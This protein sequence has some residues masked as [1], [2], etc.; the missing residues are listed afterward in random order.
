MS[1]NNRYVTGY[2]LLILTVLMSSCDQQL[3]STDELLGADT[4]FRN[5]KIYTVDRNRT[6]AEALAIKDG[7]ITYVGSD[8]D[9]LTLIGSNTDVIDLGARMVLPG[10]QDVHI[11]P[12]WGGVEASACDLNGLPGVTEYRS[13]ISEYAAANPNVEWIL[14]GGWSMPVFGPGG[15]P[16]RSIIDELVP[17]R[18]VFLTSADGHSG[19]A[20]SRA[21]EIAGITSNTPDPI[22]GRIDRDPKT[23]EPIGSLQEGATTLVTD[24]I[25]PTTLAVRKAG[26]HYAMNMLNGYGITSI[27]A[28]MVTSDELEAYQSIE[29]QGELNL[30]VV[31][32]LW[33]EREKGLEQIEYLETL[34]TQ[35]KSDLIRPTTVKIMQ[36]GVMENY[37][38][39]LLEPYFVPSNT[40]GIPMVEP[41][42]L[43]SA[44][45]ALDASGFQ[46]HFHAIGDAAIRQALNAVEESI[47]ENGQLGHRHHISHLQ[48]INPEDIERFAE[49]SVVANFQPLWAY[50]D[51]YITDLTA[52]FLGDKRM[53]W[54]YPIR[55]IQKSGG[56][57][58]FGSD[59]SVSTAN[60]FHQMETAITRMSAIE[61]TEAEPLVIEE[62]IDRETAIEAFTINAAYVNRSEH[63]TGSIEVGKYADLI[64]L[65]QNLFEVNELDI[66]ETKVMLTLFEGRVVH[67]NISEF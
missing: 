20:N 42:L 45:T 28:A 43:K 61:E 30:R 19:W 7:R 11:H 22:D 16:N 41:E 13:A 66:S 4:V 8:E 27:Q 1:S 53:R 67:G 15:A 64:V 10:L 2:V 23:G 34:R 60:P 5:G 9:V 21:L 58:A 33:W 29:R 24:H 18:P 35:Y 49:L 39:A 25:P 6:W 52:P 38:A 32:S 17:D 59:W 62:R 57:I 14:G 56:M 37:T 47:Y 54:M 26:L 48:L 63:E 12:I 51:D 50:T 3:V 31:A 44:V 40:R 65:T 55:S 46:I 36:D